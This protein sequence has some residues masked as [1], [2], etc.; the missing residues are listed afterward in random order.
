VR[1]LC[2]GAALGSIVSC[3]LL[4]AAPADGSPPSS[5]IPT[6]PPLDVVGATATVTSAA[7]GVTAPVLNASASTSAASQLSSSERA[8]AA[9]ID[10]VRR[11]HGGAALA[12]SSGLVRA[13]EA[14]GDSMARLGYFSH[15][16]RDGT[17]FWR[18]IARYYPIS[19]A[20]KWSVG[21]DLFWSVSPASTEGITRAWLASPEHRRILLGH[22]SQVGVAIVHVTQAPGVF[23]DQDVIIVVADFGSRSR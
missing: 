15:S 7:T 4:V 6:P 8:L 12:V 21:E 11:R 22:W 19:G 16:S 1:R 23:G 10:A 14:H 3:A 13:A 9:G 18:R 17:L 20:R 2:H 5:L